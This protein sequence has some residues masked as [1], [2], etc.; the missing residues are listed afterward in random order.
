MADALKGMS[1]YTLS[2]ESGRAAGQEFHAALLRSTGNVTA[3][4]GAAVTWTAVYKGL[5][6][7]RLRDS[8][9]DQQC[10]YDAVAA[11]EA[12]A[13]RGAMADLI[14]LALHDTTNAREA[15]NRKLAGAADL[16]F[17]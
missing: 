14:D 13:A 11:Q 6:S 10:V 9:P 16:L 2:S 5:H 1:R 4:V 17:I 12:P 7:P 15:S 8:L 3:E